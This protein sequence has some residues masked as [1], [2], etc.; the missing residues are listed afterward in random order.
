MKPLRVLVLSDTQI[1]ADSKG[2]TRG[3]DLDT[4]YPVLRYIKDHKWDMWIQVGDF[5]DFNCIS[6]HNKED[7]R[8]VEGQRIK[9]DYAAGNL[10]LDQLQLAIGE[11]TPGVILEGNHEYRM[12]HLIDKIP[13]LEGWMEVDKGL[14]LEERGIKYV[15]TWSTGKPFH[16]GKAAF[17]HGL[18]TN[19]HHAKKTV[20]RY[21]T[22]IFYGHTHDVQEYSA[23]LKG[24]DKTIVGSS[25][26]C[27]CVYDLP[28]M[29]GR[30]S[31]W[32]QSFSVFHF[33][34]NGFF[35]HFPV[36]IFNH[37]FMSPEGKFYGPKK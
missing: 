29:R 30:P 36:R 14:R 2:R 3:I 13:A 19:D 22:N 10:I 23:E 24:D 9:K 15:R 17:I 8:A 4:W 1:Y 31:K 35:N 16:L 28:Y 12:E 11:K 18:Y 33:R 6:S 27:L 25:L 20:S 26:G 5:L 7:L 37:S 21:G 34:E 32:Q